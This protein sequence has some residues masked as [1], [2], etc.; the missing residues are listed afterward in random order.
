MKTFAD[1]KRKFKENIIVTLYQHDSLTNI[2]KYL[3]VP[4]KIAK[5]QT[6]A[7]MFEGGSWLH[8]GKASDWVIIDDNTFK[9]RCFEDKFMYYK[10]QEA[11]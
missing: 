3:N 10:I 8:F 2:H 7:I 1:I 6:N 11:A 4:R 9:V 5:L